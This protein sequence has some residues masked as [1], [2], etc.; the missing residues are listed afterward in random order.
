VNVNLVIVNAI[1]VPLIKSTINVH[2]VII[3]I[4]TATITHLHF[5]PKE[6]HVSLSVIDMIGK[7]IMRTFQLACVNYVTKVATLAKKD[8][9]KLNA[10]FVIIWKSIIMELRH[11]YRLI[12][13]V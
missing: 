9:H 2:L 13:N 5:Y 10:L 8:L 7:A 6:I 4:S 1:L 11:T 3:N 12:K